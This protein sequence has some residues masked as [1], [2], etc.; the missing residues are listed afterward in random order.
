[1]SLKASTGL[2]SQLLDT[3][4]FRTIF[5][6]SYLRL[7][8]GPVPATADAPLDAANHLLVT[9][10]N[11]AT[12]TGLTFETAA[13]AGAIAKKA[14][15]TWRGVAILTGTVSF[16]R[17]ITS[18]DTGLVSATLPRL[19]GTAGL[20]GSDLVLTTASIVNATSYPIDDYAVTLPTL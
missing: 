9:L 15:E 2:R 12:A 19:Q 3:A 10:S 11:N 18:P 7:Y 1:M 17:L 8:D 20:V 16:Y 13:V 6:L 4:P 5:N 14:T